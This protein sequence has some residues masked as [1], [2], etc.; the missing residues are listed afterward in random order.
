MTRCIILNVI[1]FYAVHD[2]RHGGGAGL[3]LNRCGAAATCGVKLPLVGCASLA[4]QST[5]RFKS[6]HKGIAARDP[7]LL[8]AFLVLL[9]LSLFLFLITV[10]IVIIT[11]AVVVSGPATPSRDHCA[12]RAAQRREGKRRNRA[13]RRQWTRAAESPSPCA[14]TA[15]AVCAQPR[16]V[17]RLCS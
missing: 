9:L 3:A 6:R 4:P 8:R 7:R 17:G 5:S 1:S 13:N 16:H 2:S 12:D 10:I 11:I 14:A 15:G